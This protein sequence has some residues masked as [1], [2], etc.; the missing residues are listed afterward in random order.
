[1][2]LL[3]CDFSSSPSRR[4]TIV[5]AVGHLSGDCVCLDGIEAFATLE[6][7]GQRLAQGQWVG[8]FDLPF[9][10]PRE[11]VQTLGWP[12]TWHASAQ[13][14]LAQP[15]SALRE[16]FKAFCAARPVGGK[17]AHRATDGPAGSSPS[18]KWVNPPVAWM[19]HA[20]LP[21]L[22]AVGATFPAHADPDPH[23][24]P[25][26]DH[27]HDHDP[28]SGSGSGPGAAAVNCG[29]SQRQRVALEAYPGLLARELLGGA[30]SY[31]SDDVAR[32]TPARSLA[33]EQ[34]LAQLVAGHTRL[35]LSVQLTPAQAHAMV[36]DAQGDT[37]DALLA[38]VQAAWCWRAHVRGHANWGLPAG[39]DPLEGWIATA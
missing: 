35:G 23:H 1:M 24:Y 26:H 31:K 34:L 4:K 18:M 12:A 3:G 8:G 28:G 32:Q 10:L 9:G 13:H 19:M 16:Q 29:D 36:A 14:Y 38:L 15:R 20:G 25:G 30:T 2:P 27:D 5:L 11:L 39:V 37:L 7:W 22:L 17:F 21:W 6:A 33:R